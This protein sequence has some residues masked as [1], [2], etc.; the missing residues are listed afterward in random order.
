MTEPADPTA[1]PVPVS[2]PV[3]SM[4]PPGPA[5]WPWPPVW[6]PPRTGSSRLFEVFKVAALGAAALLLISLAIG[7][8]ATM[9]LIAG[10]V[11]SATSA[12]GGVTGGLD[13]SLET[14]RSAVAAASQG[15]AD[16]TDPTHPPREGVVQDTE[17]D[18]LRKVRIGETI[19]EAG[20]YR[21]S[22]KETRLREASSPAEYRQYA[23]IHRELIT[24]KSRSVLGVPV[25]TDRE[26]AD[27]YLDRGELFQIGA[28]LYKVNWVSASQQQVA[29]VTLRYP[30]QAAGPIEFRVGG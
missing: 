20:G 2:K 28:T 16:L 1:R 8:L 22:L 10:T 21:F 23:V 9:V 26:E 19:G 18:S 3:H 17:F 4:E 5:E 12:L 13:R 24:P 30:D 11:T 25:G 7:A 14:A 27:F 15:L 29:L 6:Y